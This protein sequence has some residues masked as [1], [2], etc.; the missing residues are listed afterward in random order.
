VVPLALPGT[1]EVAAPFIVRLIRD[2]VSAWWAGQRDAWGRWW[3]YRRDDLRLQHDERQ[4]IAELA[5]LTG[6][7]QEHGEPRLTQLIRQAQDAKNKI[8]RRRLRAATEYLTAEGARLLISAP[9]AANAWI[10]EPGR[11]GY[12]SRIG[13]TEFANR[14]RREQRGRRQG[15][16]ALVGVIAAVTGLIAAATGLLAIRRHPPAEAPRLGESPRPGLVSPTT[17]PPKATSTS[18]TATTSTML[19]PTSTVPAAHDADAETGS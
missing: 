10:G 8:E 5:W 19:T 4:V 16:V 18:T 1:F 14:I 9:G 3:R 2:W 17:L 11:P 12:L 13:V 15:L 7:A 6:E